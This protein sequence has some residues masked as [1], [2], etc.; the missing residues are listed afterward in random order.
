MGIENYLANNVTLFPNPAREYVDVRVDGDVNVTAMEVFDVYG[1][2]INTVV[3]VDNPT[4]IN[5]S[6]IADGMYFVRV[7]T[8][9]GVVTKTFVK[10]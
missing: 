5:V 7:T 8:E 9:K 2:L 10:R 4:R 1:K 6:G 3:V